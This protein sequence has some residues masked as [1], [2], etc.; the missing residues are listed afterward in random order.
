MKA[1]KKVAVILVGCG[2]MDGADIREAVSLLLALS[3][4]NIEYECFALNKD[5]AYVYDHCKGK[6]TTEEKR[7]ILTESARITR[8]KVA[9]IKLL[10]IKNFDG[11]AFVGGYGVGMGLSNFLITKDTNNY[12]IDEDIKNTII[13]FYEAKKAIYFLCSSST[14]LSQLP[15]KPKVTLGFETGN[16]AKNFQ[17]KMNL[18]SK[19]ENSPEVDYDNKII[20][21][22][23]YLLDKISITELYD[24][25]YDGANKFQEL[26]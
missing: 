16:I 11:L 6:I 14:L 12:S 22:P 15:F 17:H 13:N 1:K 19:N 3:Q 26:L 5:Q 21:I 24:G 18:I 4:L 8:G 7:N 10:N 20:S 9:D 2:P 23:C 25:I